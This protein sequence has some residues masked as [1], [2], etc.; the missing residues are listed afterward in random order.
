M[1]LVVRD[2]VPLASRTTLGIGGAAKHYCEPQSPAEVS[3]ALAWAAQKNIPLYVIGRGSNL[4]VADRGVDALVM[5]QRA[6]A[7]TAVDDATVDVDAGVNWDDFVAW[8]VARDLAGVECLSGI[9]GDVGSAPIQNIGAYGQEL[10]ETLVHVRA[11]DRQTGQP[12]TLDHADCELAYRDSMFKRQSEPRYIIT[13]VRCRLTPG[14]AP[15]IAYAELERAMHDTPTTVAAVR[16]KIIALRRAKS[17]VL[18]PT[19]ENNRSAG[20]FFVN[21]TVAA[22]RV[23]AIAKRAA[24]LAPNDVMP[25]YPAADGHTKLSAAWMIER[26]GFVRGTQRGRVGISSKHTLALVNR[27]DATAA[28]LIAFAV[29]VKHRVQEAFDVT[30]HPEPRLVGFAPD[31]VSA[32]L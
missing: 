7:L 2:N 1:S 10:S 9:P 32:L 19:D 8:C 17:M 11:I 3:E 22:D 6:C 5:R 12:V 27:G 16:D 4:L 30:L 29:E 15:K 23:P 21:P 25:A 18:D 31:E 28:E 20:S 14:G 13:R 24:E 26:A